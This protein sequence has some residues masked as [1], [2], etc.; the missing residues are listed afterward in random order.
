M[1]TLHQVDDLDLHYFDFV[2]AA[3]G[4]SSAYCFVQHIAAPSSD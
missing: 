2:G 4:G 3:C 1:S